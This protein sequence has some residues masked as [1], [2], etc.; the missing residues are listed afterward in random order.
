MYHVRFRIDVPGQEKRVYKSLPICPVHGV[1][2]LTK[3]E[4]ERRAKELIAHSG[5][6]TEEHFNRVEAVNLGITFRQQAER[7][8]EDSQHRKRKPVKPNTVS[9]WRSILDKWLL[10]ELGSTPLSAIDNPQGK[11]LVAKLADAGLSPNSIRCIMNVMKSVIASILDEKAD[12]VYPRQWN[13]K[14]MDTPIVGDD[15]KTPT[16][17]RGWRSDTLDT[18]GPPC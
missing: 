9:H 6:D 13:N 3:P 11:A 17:T 5:A 1:G 12:Q 18:E 8:L 7:W 4:R 16:L 10:P 15:L 14:Y 2:K